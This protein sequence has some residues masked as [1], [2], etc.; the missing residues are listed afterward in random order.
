M[1]RITEKHLQAKVE[2]I[3]ECLG[4]PNEY[5]TKGAITLSRRYGYR[6]IDKYTGK[7]CT[8]LIFGLSASESNIF[9]NGILSGFG[10]MEEKVKREEQQKEEE[11]KKKECEGFSNY[12]TAMVALAV[13]NNKAIYAATMRLYSK[14]KGLTFKTF[15]TTLFVWSDTIQRDYNLSGDWLEQVNIRELV[16]HFNEIWGEP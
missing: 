14:H 3:N 11:R 16:N 15:I 1:S 4:L 9:L 10:L 8:T 13:A 6:A 2:R 5:N 7:C 12:E